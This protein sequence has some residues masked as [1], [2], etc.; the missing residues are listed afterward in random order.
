MSFNAGV[1]MM[2]DVYLSITADYVRE[3]LKTDKQM[4]M[5]RYIL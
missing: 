4:D 2:P 5:R 3:H 1:E